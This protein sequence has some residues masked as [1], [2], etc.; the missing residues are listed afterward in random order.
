MANLISYPI[1]LVGLLLTCSLPFLYVRIYPSFKHSKKNLD[2]IPLFW[3]L[4]KIVYWGPEEGVIITRNKKLNFTSNN[5]IGHEYGGQKTIFPCFGDRLEARLKLGSEILRWNDNHRTLT[6]DGLRVRICIAIRWKI[7]QPRDYYYSMNRH[8]NRKRINNP[9]SHEEL[10]QMADHWLRTEIEGTLRRL[11]RELTVAK[12]ISFTSEAM[13]A[14]SHRIANREHG[15]RLKSALKTE[16]ESSLKDYG[17]NI[18]EVE[19][20]DIQFE[21]EIQDGFNKLKRAYLAESESEHIGR[22]KL[23]ELEPL[24]ATLGTDA[25]TLIEAMKN[26]NGSMLMG[27][28]PHLQNLFGMSMVNGVQDSNVVIEQKE[29]SKI[30]Q[31]TD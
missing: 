15:D 20:Q 10:K 25:V 5:V 19:I 12:L 26:M 22:A 27:N 4:V 18:I 23:A 7:S 6:K 28:I 8:F 3:G 13:E 21:S 31:I 9:Y 14:D 29:A 2:V 11:V 1:V 16:F 24:L 17:I 30:E